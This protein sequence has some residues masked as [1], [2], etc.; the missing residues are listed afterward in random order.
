LPVPYE[1]NFAV[2]IFVNHKSFI[3]P[4]SN[5]GNLIK[6]SS[7]MSTSYCNNYSWRRKWHIYKR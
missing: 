2:K 5:F 7:S 6:P 3:N 1:I 4:S